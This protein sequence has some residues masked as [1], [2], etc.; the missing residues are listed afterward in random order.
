MSVHQVSKKSRRDIPHLKESKQIVRLMSQHSDIDWWQ[1]FNDNV[2]RQI[3]KLKNKKFR[4]NYHAN[5]QPTQ[6]KQNA[7]TCWHSDWT[8]RRTSWSTCRC[9]TIE[10]IWANKPWEAKPADP[11]GSAAND[12]KQCDDRQYISI[13]FAIVWIVVSA[14]SE[15]DCIR[16]TGDLL[17]CSRSL[18]SILKL[19]SNACSTR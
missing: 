19:G 7:V 18:S 10:T 13:W 8:H 15:L 14:W 3:S 11:R 5:E 4:I 17:W 16:Q 6:L 1:F 9:N 2:K 12:C